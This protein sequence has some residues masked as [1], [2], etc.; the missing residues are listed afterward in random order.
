MHTDVSI[1]SARSVGSS[2]GMDGN[3]VQ[4]TEV[5]SDTTDLVLKDLV[6]ETSLE[7]TLTSRCRRDFH[8][9]LT[10]TEDDIVLLRCDGSGVERSVGNV[11]FKDG[12]VPGG[13]DL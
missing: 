11:G 12:E 7:F 6:V 4:R 13:Q 10:S 3:G 1:L 5:A 2:V 8:R 9:G